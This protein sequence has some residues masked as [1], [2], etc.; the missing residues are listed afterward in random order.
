MNMKSKFTSCF[1]N[2]GIIEILALIWVIV[3]V[4]FLLMEGW[5]WHDAKPSSEPANTWMKDHVF[6]I[7]GHEFYLVQERLTHSKKCL[8]KIV[9]TA[10]GSSVSSK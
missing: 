10:P 8:C 7:E 3:L 1:R 6:M 4:L 9:D 5:Q 2:L